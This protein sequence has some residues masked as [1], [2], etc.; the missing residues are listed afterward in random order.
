MGLKLPSISAREIHIQAVKT[1]EKLSD[2][3]FYRPSLAGRH[4]FGP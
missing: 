2:D 4:K 1:A 3:L